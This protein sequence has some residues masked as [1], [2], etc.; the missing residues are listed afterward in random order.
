MISPASD[1]INS[2]ELIQAL[3]S[4]ELEVEGRLAGASNGT[5][6]CIVPITALS[7]VRCV[8]KPVAGERPLWDFPDETLS[9]REV[10]SYE[11]SE[12]LGLHVVPPTVWRDEGPAG[13]GMCQ[14]W[15]DEI[16]EIQ[17]VAVM[18]SGEDLTNW[19]HVF[20]G[21]DDYGGAVSLVHARDVTLQMV[22]LL[23]VVIN[24]ADRKGGHLLV[25][26]QHRVW[27]IDHGVSFST[28]EKLRT[29]LWG[30][31]GMPIPDA[32]SAPVA[33]LSEM[34]S[35]GIPESVTGWLSTDEVE[36]LEIR[37]KRLLAD[38]TFPVPSPN[39]PAIPWPVF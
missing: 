10:A 21:S 1:W 26:E 34:L 35:T 16:S 12:A 18:P 36:A 29:V 37:I 31:A 5:L 4:G 3:T 19:H 14:V 30:W 28:E 8:Y 11:M 7:S 23:D 32:L 9:K 20:D 27:A 17:L 15:I 39:W 22:A 25:D 24:N 6:R 33:A 38:G 13:P 2:E